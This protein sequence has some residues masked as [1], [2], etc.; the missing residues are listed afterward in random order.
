VTDID[1]RPGDT[2]RI[3]TP[4]IGEDKTVVVTEAYEEEGQGP[5][6]YPAG[7]TV[8]KGLAATTYTYP[9]KDR[10]VTVV[11]RPEVEP[12][13]TAIS[14]ETEVEAL[15][16]WEIELLKGGAQPSFEEIVH[17]LYAEAA[18]LLLRKHR[19]YGPGNIA[20]APGG[21]LNGLRVRLYDKLARLNNL[22]DQ[23]REPEFETLVDTLMDIANYGLIG[24]LVERGD[25]PTLERQRA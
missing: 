21:A 3:V 15:A 8:G 10:T 11:S 7:F 5:D 14:P 17:A 19:D 2:V 25:W 4:S 1:I 23:D 12:E 13:P 20:G 22:L 6:G 16:D 24:V 9:W 18:D